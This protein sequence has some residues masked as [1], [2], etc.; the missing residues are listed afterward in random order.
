MIG[1]LF[2]WL[3]RAPPQ[4]VSDTLWQQTLDALP[5]LDRLTPDETARLRQL[6]EAFLAEK[7]FSSAGGLA[8]D[9][10]L[11]VNIA[12]QGCLPILELGLTAY[13]DWLGIVVYPDE[14]VIPRQITDEDGVVHEYEEV[15][16]GEAWLGGPLLLSWQDAQMAGDGYNVVIHEFAHKLDM[17][18][19]EVDGIPALHSGLQPAQW[20]ATLLAA[21]EDFCQRVDAGEDTALDPYAAEDPAEFFAVL[22]EA[23]FETPELVRDDYPAFYQLLCRYYRQ[24]PDRPLPPTQG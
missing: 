5:F 4:R 10:A 16:A 6:V 23:F 24:Q 12:T 11:C 9:D 15:A 1:A 17:L 20:E 19:G 13:R 8:L 3:R 7:R 22:S 2:S 21:Y 18:N 14:F